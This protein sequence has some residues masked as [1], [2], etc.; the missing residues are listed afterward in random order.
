MTPDQ[1]RQIYQ[2]V[3]S[4]PKR[5]NLEKTLKQ[6]RKTLSLQPKKTCNCGK[7]LKRAN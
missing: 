5:K 6:P 4:Q 2:Q 3:K 1:L 7:K